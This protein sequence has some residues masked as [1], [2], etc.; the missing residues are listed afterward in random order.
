VR[1]VADWAFGELGIPRLEIT[2]DPENMPSIRVAERAGF[3][4]TAYLPA[5]VETRDGARD[6]VLLCRGRA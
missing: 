4:R 5:W 3:E 1:L 6:R 2:A